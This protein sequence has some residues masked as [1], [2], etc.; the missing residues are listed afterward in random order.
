[1]ENSTNGSLNDR[2]ILSLLENNDYQLPKL[3]GDDK[4]LLNKVVKMVN[5]RLIEKLE[6]ERRRRG[7]LKVLLFLSLIFCRNIFRIYFPENSITLTRKTK[8][9]DK[10]EEKIVCLACRRITLW[11]TFLY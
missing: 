4:E 7:N 11:R 9:I 8:M 10:K 3:I 1:M 5:D 2:D 6:I